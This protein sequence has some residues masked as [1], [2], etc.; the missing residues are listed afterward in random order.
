MTNRPTPTTAPATSPESEP[1]YSLAVRKLAAQAAVTAS[2]KSGRP[3]DP[4]V[5]VLADSLAAESESDDAKRPKSVVRFT[6]AVRR[7]LRRA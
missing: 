7:R 3:V 6:L 1:K 2:K 4:R 5:H